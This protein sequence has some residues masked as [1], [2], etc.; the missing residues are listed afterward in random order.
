M[1]CM[2]DLRKQW[3]F[4]PAVQSEREKVGPTASEIDP[5]DEASGGMSQTVTNSMEVQTDAVWLEADRPILGHANTN[6]KVNAIFFDEELTKI[7]QQL[8]SIHSTVVGRYDESP[9]TSAINRQP[10][11]NIPFERAFY[12]PTLVSPRAKLTPTGLRRA[13]VKDVLDDWRRCFVLYSDWMRLLP[14]F[15]QLSHEDQIILAKNRFSIFHWWICGN[16]SAESGRDGV[17]YGNGAYFPRGSHIQCVPDINN[18]ANK[19]VTSYVAPLRELQL[20]DV[21]RCCFLVIALFNDGYVSDLSQ[22]SIEGKDQI[23]NSRDKYIRVLY[24][25]IL[26]QIIQNQ[27]S[28]NKQE[29]PYMQIRAHS[30][31]GLRMAR[32]LLLNSSL[33]TLVCLSSNQGQLGDVLHVVDWEVNS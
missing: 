22:I 4:V 10:F 2:T 12:E 8:V 23:R 1:A 25:H 21:E 14:D 18:V 17:V 11:E 5:E 31:A 33:T 32:I 7:G 9:S 24:N 28:N 6:N 29:N 3:A 26:F 27:S 13:T 16:W 30:D 20:T 19:M 15:C